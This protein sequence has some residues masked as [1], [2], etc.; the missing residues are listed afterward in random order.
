MRIYY[1]DYLDQVE[2]DFGIRP[3]HVE[4][5][6]ILGGKPNANS[7]SNRLFNNGFLKQQERL[8]LDAHYYNK[9]IDLN[10]IKTNE[11]L[12]GAVSDD[13]LHEKYYIV[14]FWE[15][16]DEEITSRIK[17]DEVNG[18]PLGVDYITNKL[19][20]KPENLRIISMLGDDMDGGQYPIRN[21]DLLLIDI[22]RNQPYE[23]GVFFVTTHGGTRLYVRRIF[24]RMI[25][26]ARYFTTI[27]NEIYKK[28]IEKYWTEEKWKEA[29]VQIVG[30]V[31]KNMS[32]T[33]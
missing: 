26:S 15:G 31:I 30:R 13:K 28:D 22:S 23:T 10:L 17:D 33:I 7:L 8:L 9:E 14:S 6:N 5:S 12:I 16:V 29:D 2:K 20:C 4:I 24:E 27:D 18:L 19:K 1:R 21:K 11:N 32:Y 3:T 25:D